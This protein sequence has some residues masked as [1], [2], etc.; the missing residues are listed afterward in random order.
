[1]KRFGVESLDGIKNSS[2]VNTS[3]TGHDQ[4]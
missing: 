4:V 3:V 1:V 2:V